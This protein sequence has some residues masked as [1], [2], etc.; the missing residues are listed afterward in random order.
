MRQRVVHLLEMLDP[1]VVV[2]WGG[3]RGVAGVRRDVDPATRTAVI[4]DFISNAAIGDD[5]GGVSAQV[6][7]GPPTAGLQRRRYLRPWVLTP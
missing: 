6:G 1:C 3:V 5:D 2:P 7:P 4:T